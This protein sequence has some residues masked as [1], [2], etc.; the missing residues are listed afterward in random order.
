MTDFA[1]V[2]GE[3]QVVSARR[4]VAAL[5]YH[6]KLTRRQLQELLY[7]GARYDTGRA[8]QTAVLI[9]FCRDHGWLT[10]YGDR[11]LPTP[12]GLKQLEFAEGIQPL[13]AS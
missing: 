11:F 6:R 9:H 8:R 7:P 13:E 5:A 1:V 2:K 10:S 3:P 12:E 4:L